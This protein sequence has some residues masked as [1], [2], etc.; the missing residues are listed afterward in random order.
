MCC[1]PFSRICEWTL[2]ASSAQHVCTVSPSLPAIGFSTINHAKD[3]KS[4][5]QTAF[6][7]VQVQHPNAEFRVSSFNQLQKAFD[8]YQVWHCNW[9]C[10]SGLIGLKPLV[11]YCKKPLVIYC[12]LILRHIAFVIC[13]PLQSGWAKL[14]YLRMNMCTLC[15]PTMKTPSG[16]DD[17]EQ[18]SC[19]AS[20]R[21]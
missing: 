21:G 7:P 18:Q 9:Q 5:H 3:Q 6:L 13:M 17:P 15:I 16:A 1:V 19:Y 4:E 11:I 2:C 20:S 10:H 8:E 14:Q 12:N